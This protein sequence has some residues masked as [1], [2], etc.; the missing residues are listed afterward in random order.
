MLYQATDMSLKGGSLSILETEDLL[1]F[2]EIYVVIFLSQGVD[3]TPNEQSLGFLI[4]SLSII[5][6]K[7]NE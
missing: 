6:L 3:K 2:I 7:E 1:I 5:I 4:E